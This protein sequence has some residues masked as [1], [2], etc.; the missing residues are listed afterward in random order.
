M[1]RD[2]RERKDEMLEGAKLIGA[3]AATIAL[4]GAAVGIG[5]VFSSL[6]HSV[7]RNPSLA[8]QLFGYAILGFALTEA[9]A[10]FALMMA[11]LGPDNYLLANP[12]S[13]II[14]GLLSKCRWGRFLFGLSSFLFCDFSLNMMPGGSGGG[15]GNDLFGNSSTGNSETGGNSVGSSEASINQP[16]PHSP[17][18]EGDR[19][20]PFIPEDP[21]ENNLIP[22]QQRM[23][24]LGHRLSINSLQKNLSSSEWGS[25]VAAQITVEERVETTLINDG[26]SPDAVLNKRHQ[27]RGFLFYPG[28]TSL[29]EKTYVGY[30]KSLDN[31]GTH[32]SIP[33]KRVIQAIEKHEL[34]LSGGD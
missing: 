16:L 9:I 25:I 13:F 21:I 23:E 8:K 18:P 6:I 5:N 27:I 1:K 20:G 7:A 24:E 26:F 34:D 17:E 22:A 19:G 11:F 12:M 4:A 28:G 14:K 32:A 33:Y 10:L 3:G 2:E 30:V 15:A 29:S 31:L